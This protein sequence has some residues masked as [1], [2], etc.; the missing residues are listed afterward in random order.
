MTKILDLYPR[1]VVEGADAALAFY[2][3]R[4]ARSVSERYAG[5]DGQVV[6]AMV[7]AGPVR[8]AVKDADDDDPA[9]TGG[10]VPVIIALYVDRRRRG[11]RADGGA[12]ARR[13]LPGRR[14][15]A[16]AS[17]AA[18]CA[19]P[20]GHLWMIAATAPPLR[21]RWSRGVL[22]GRQQE[23]RRDRGD[24][25]A[26]TGQAEAVGGGAGHRRPGRRPRRRAPAAPRRGGCRSS[27]AL[28][29]T[30]TAALP[31]VQPVAATQPAHLAEQR[32]AARACPLRAPGAEDR[33]D[34]A[35]PGRRQQRVTQRVGGHVTV[36]VAGAAVDAVPAAARRPSTPGPP[37]P[38]ARRCR[39]RPS[40]RDRPPLDQQLA[41]AP[42]PTRCARRTR[43]GRPARCAR[44]RRRRGSGGRRPSGPAARSPPRGRR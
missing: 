39:R 43:P 13:D 24:A 17:A 21:S 15:A 16:T 27:G 28:P 22:G 25:L 36:G 19:D 34:V 3:P 37:R 5:P 30:C 20:F 6:H 23:R 1:L 31:T 26:A 38:G 4:S 40:R 9:P 18:A 42:G 10:G 8:F 2:A 33:A 29:I 32:D 14:P 44:R 35:E 7:T 41:P 11:G 12:R